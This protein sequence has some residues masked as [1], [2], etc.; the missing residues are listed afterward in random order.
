M[1]PQLPSSER[2]SGLYIEAHFEA[3]LVRI[4]RSEPISRVA[5]A[6]L[7]APM[8]T[9]DY[10]DPSKPD[11]AEI[12]LS[13]LNADFTVLDAFAWPHAA[14]AF[15]DRPRGQSESGDI[16]GGPVDART[17]LRILRV[18]I[19]PEAEYL[20]FPWFGVETNCRNLQ[21]GVFSAAHGTVSAEAGRSAVADSAAAA[22]PHAHPAEA[23]AT[24]IH[25]GE[26]EAQMVGEDDFLCTFRQ[27]RQRRSNPRQQ[28][29]AGHLLRCGDSGR[30]LHRSRSAAL[31]RRARWRSRM[32]S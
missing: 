15:F 6:R 14:R 10:A 17:T 32:R 11:A 31:Q 29:T 20:V 28:R 1:P 16:E 3:D 22:D 26:G 21:A 25:S 23:S 27:L 5:R 24:A 9:E 30:W 4:V 19:R 18:P 13:I 2:E 7:R 12:V 8:L